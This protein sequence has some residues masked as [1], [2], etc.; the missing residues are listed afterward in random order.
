MR[1]LVRPKPP[2]KGVPADVNEA[3]REAEFKSMLAL[4]Q[5]NAPV[6]PSAGVA[7]NMDDYK[8][9]LKK[10]R[11]A[12]VLKAAMKDAG[13]GDISKQIRFQKVSEEQPK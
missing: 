10:R 13:M 7:G 11:M 5:A 1:R 4:D 8:I 6:V 3:L 2:E 12:N 9:V